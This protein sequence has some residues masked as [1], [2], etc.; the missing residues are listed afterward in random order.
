MLKILLLYWLTSLFLVAEDQNELKKHVPNYPTKLEHSL[1]WIAGSFPAAFFPLLPSCYVQ[2]CSQGM[3]FFQDCIIYLQLTFAHCC[4]LLPVQLLLLDMCSKVLKSPSVTSML[5]LRKV[6]V[7][8]KQV[9]NHK[10]MLCFTVPK[11]VLSSTTS[12]VESR[13]VLVDRLCMFFCW[14]EVSCGGLL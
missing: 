11:Q 3:G 8:G 14:K 5:F 4:V 7:Q 1:L 12:A 6:F 2:T 9:R 10:R 13:A